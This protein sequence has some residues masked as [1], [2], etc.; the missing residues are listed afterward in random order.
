M[1]SETSPA[2]SDDMV[3]RVAR[4]LYECESARSDAVDKLLSAAKGQPVKFRM[5]HWDDVAD[6]YRSDARAAIAAMSPQQ[7][8]SEAL[9]ELIAGDADLYDTPSARITGDKDRENPVEGAQPAAWMYDHVMFG[10]QIFET[11]WD[12]R[13]GGTSI[14]WTETPLYRHPPASD[15]K[16]A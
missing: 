10:T 6:L 5:E 1:T 4:A 16:P 14:G 7:V 12:R 11:R 15:G 8:N 13:A 3:D 9:S 2:V